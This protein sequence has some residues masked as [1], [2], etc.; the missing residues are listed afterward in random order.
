MGVVVALLSAVLFGISTPLAKLLLG[1]LQ[2]GVQ[3]SNVA[4]AMQIPPTLLASLLYGGSGLGLLLVLCWRRIRQQEIAPVPPD[5]RISL[6][7][8]I[9][10]GGIVAPVLLLFGIRLAT[11]S[12]ASLLLN[13]EGVFTSLIAWLIYKEHTDRN[14]IVGMIL[15]TCASALLFYQPSPEI[16]RETSQLSWDQLWGAALIVGAC[17][18]WGIDN[19]LTQKASS[20][21]AVLLACLKGLTAGFV[22]LLVSLSIG[23]WVTL[24][25]M[26]LVS[27]MS[28]GFFSYGLSLVFFIVALRFLGT[29][30]T[31]AYF[32][33][34]P[35]V[36]ALVSL[37]LW[38]SE[39]NVTFVVACGLMLLGLWMHLREKHEHEHIHEPMEHMHPH[40]H[41][42]H[43]QHAHPELTPEE[44]ASVK[45]SHAHVHA[46]LVHTH[47]HTPDAHHRHA[48]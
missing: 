23:A 37:V 22:N 46:Y 44:Y 43:H 41:D 3:E 35:F 4:N 27:S 36:G 2:G 10:F 13:L 18:C 14:N 7:G 40:K 47:P 39:V 17:L 34:A 26:Y 11:A 12:S 29:A 19:N 25:A 9:F 24:P 15:I 48:H 8:A 45:H 30:R 32:A 1:G 38:P 6:A 21:D 33:A 16:A 20:A 5:A 42:E 28:L 31:G